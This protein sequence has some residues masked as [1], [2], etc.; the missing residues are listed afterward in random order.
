[1][2]RRKIERAEYE[3][4]ITKNG[5]EF[6]TIPELKISEKDY[7]SEKITTGIERLDEMLDGGIYKGSSVLIVGMTGTGKTTF[8]LHFAIANA[9]QGRKVAYITFEEPI[10]QIIRSAKTTGCQSRK[11][12]KE[13]QNLCMGA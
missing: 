5:I 11:F 13:S 10:D 2:R 7:T 9:L 1:M 6:L 4:V 3:Y 8:S 12:R